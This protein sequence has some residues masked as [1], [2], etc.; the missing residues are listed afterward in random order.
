[1]HRRVAAIECQTRSD[2]ETGSDAES[3]KRAQNSANEHKRAQTLVSKRVQV[4]TQELKRVQ[5]TIRVFKTETTRFETH[6][7]GNSQV[8][9]KMSAEMPTKTSR[10][11]LMANS[12]VLTK[13]YT[14]VCLVSCQMFCFHKFC[15]LPIRDTDMEGK[16]EG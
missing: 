12:T 14:K 15:L 11:V 3:R 16:T 5:K 2:A 8:Y 9:K 6:R 10:T 4:G 1:M 13:M 7:F